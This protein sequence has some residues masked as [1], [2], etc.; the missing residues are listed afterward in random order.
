MD[1]K[2]TQFR[3]HKTPDEFV[4]IFYNADGEFIQG[5]NYYTDDKAD[6]IATAKAEIKRAAESKPSPKS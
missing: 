3:V 2:P 6:A 4:A 5:A 1:R